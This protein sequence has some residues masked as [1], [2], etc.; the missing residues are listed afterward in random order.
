MFHS[1]FV[2]KEVKSKWRDSGILLGLFFF[3]KGNVM[4]YHYE[5]PEKYTSMY[6]VIYKCNHPVYNYCTLFKI[7][8]KGLAIIQQRFDKNTK[9]CW[10]SEIDP[11]LNDLLYLN[12]RFLDFF[13]ERADKPDDEMLYP[14]V[15]LRQIMWG[16]K[17][18][19]IKRE[20]WETY[21]D[22]HAI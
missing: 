11:W 1:A 5:K 16:L 6:G 3:K 8:E 22:R 7:G 20:R 2:T 17:M 9:H 21:F 10:W 19:P 18:K 15:S 4:R 14:T 12:V 13:K